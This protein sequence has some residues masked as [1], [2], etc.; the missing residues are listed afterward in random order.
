MARAIISRAEAKTIGYKKYFTGKPC[1]HGHISERYTNSKHCIQCL[2]ERNKTPAS[3]EYYKKYYRRYV[4]NQSEETRAYRSAIQR[5]KYR[6]RWR[7]NARH[8]SRLRKQRIKRATLQCPI[9]RIKVEQ[10]YLEAK[11]LRALGKNYNIDH[12][13][14]IVHDKVCGLHCFANL[15]IVP[16]EVNA[17]KGNSFDLDEYNKRINS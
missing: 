2:T 8:N 16:Y 13:I 15:R 10:L 14:P 17:S 12:I 9:D 6:T 11:H 4:D 5:H 1:K 3:R 7:F